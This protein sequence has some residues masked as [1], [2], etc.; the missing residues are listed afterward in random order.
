MSQWYEE[1]QAWYQRNWLGTIKNI[2]FIA[3][4]AAMTYMGISQYVLK[5]PGK[6]AL[7]MDRAFGRN[8][9]YVDDPE[10]KEAILENTGKLF[11]MPGTHGNQVFTFVP[12]DDYM[13]TEM[14]AY[15]QAFIMLK[16]QEET[17]KALAKV[18][19]IRAEQ[20]RRNAPGTYVYEPVDAAYGQAPS[21]HSAPVR[22]YG[23]PLTREEI[24]RLIDQQT[25]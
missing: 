6:K 1:D 19:E 25:R 20:A 8:I 2:A 13:T 7:M 22:F 14:Q 11:V 23:R 15:I 12:I 18:E 4:I 16:T 21:I 24:D 17:E 9:S 10:T 5:S 3:S